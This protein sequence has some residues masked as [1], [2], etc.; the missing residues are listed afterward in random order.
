MIVLLSCLSLTVVVNLDIQSAKEMLILAS[1]PEDQKMWI[2]SLSKK[3][4]KKGYIHS[5]GGGDKV[6]SG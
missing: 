4:A 6:P 5:G 2:Q 3:I 1:S